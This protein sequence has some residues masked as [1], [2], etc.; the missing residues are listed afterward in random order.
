MTIS[1][2]RAYADISGTDGISA[3]EDNLEVH[4][5]LYGDN[6]ENE[7][8]VVAFIQNPANI[9]TTY[10]GL[11]L[12]SSSFERLDETENH[13]DVTANYVNTGSPT[14]LPKLEADEV[15]WSI[16][17]GNG[18]TV[19]Q[20][21]SK[22]LVS[23]TLPSGNTKPAFDTTAAETAVGLVHRDGDFEIEGVDV[24]VGNTEISV[25][26]VWDY[27]TAITGGRLLAAA[28]YA[29]VKAINSATWEG[30][31][32]GT[33]Q[34]ESF[35]ARNRS[36]STPEYE[37]DFSFTFSR[38][39]TN[40][41]VGNGITVP[42]KKGHQHLEVLYTKQEISGLPIPVPIRAAVHDLFDEINFATALGL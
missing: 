40:I 39:L 17:G 4:Y 23:E 37:V 28:E 3:S 14:T 24:T 5:I 12:E 2:N 13:W 16:V 32:A 26:T 11:G 8:D 7:S 34:V 27:A 20:T 42:S 19:K 41:D 35:S 10:L 9:P 31:P 1:I 22:S 29:N 33:L 38:N 25:Q 21:F 15:R 6:G 18:G 36:G 30:F